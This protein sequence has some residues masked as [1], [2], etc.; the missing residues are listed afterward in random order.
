V[1]DFAQTLRDSNA[2]SVEFLNTEAETGLLFAEI[3]QGSDNAEK[4]ARNC[5]HARLAY[6]TVLRF[7]GRVSLT[8]AESESLSLQMAKLKIRLQTLGECF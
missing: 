3:A 5:A 8:E 7:I 2:T 1:Q 6:N 4:R